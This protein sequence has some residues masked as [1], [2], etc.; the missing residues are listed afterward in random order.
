MVKNDAKRGKVDGRPRKLFEIKSDDV[1]DSFGDKIVGFPRLVGVLSNYI[2]P[3][4]HEIGSICEFE[5][6]SISRERS[7]LNLFRYIYTISEMKCDKCG[8]KLTSIID[9]KKKFK[10][11]GGE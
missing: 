8:W 9:R 4:C 11:I 5:W 1:R 2:C 3:K 6:R 7:F 10:G